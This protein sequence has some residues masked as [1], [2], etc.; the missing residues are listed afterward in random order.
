MPT[1]PKILITS[2]EEI[3]LMEALIEIGYEVY[4]TIA[5]LDNTIQDILY[6]QPQ[7][8]LL[9]INLDNEI[10]AIGIAQEINNI[11][12]I[13]L[14]FIAEEGIGLNFNQLKST[15]PIA[16]F[17]K[18]VNSIDIQHAIELAR[19]KTMN[20]TLNAAPL[21]ELQFEEETILADR[22]FIRNRDRMVKIYL[23]DILYLEAARNYCKIVTSYQDYL[24]SM[25]MKTVEEKI[26]S[27]HFFRVHRSFVINLEK[28]DEILYESHVLIG[29]KEIPISKT[30]YDA[31][32]KVIRLI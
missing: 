8:V 22:I 18:P 5:G 14:I 23:E 25:P 11:G 28:I 26:N 17:S 3:Q 4:Q 27:S 15:N 30:Y 7:V 21:E 10:E 16:F 24:L 32:T 13:I 31:F 6:Y 2:S 12:E 9:S 1:T 20:L 29:K 19:D